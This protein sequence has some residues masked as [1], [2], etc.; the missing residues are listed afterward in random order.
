MVELNLE[1]LAF[2]LAFLIPVTGKGPGTLSWELLAG[3]ESQITFLLSANVNLS[4][5]IYPS[6]D[7]FHIL[8]WRRRSWS[9]FTD[10]IS[11]RVL[12]SPLSINYKRDFPYH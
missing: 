12:T 9:S 10:M 3:I 4:L 7:P 11:S 8:G 2:L 1:T 5:D 6:Q